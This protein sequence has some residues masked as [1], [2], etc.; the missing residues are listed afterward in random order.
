MLAGKTVPAVLFALGLLTSYLLSSFLTFYP[1]STAYHGAVFLKTLLDCI[2][3][4]LEGMRSPYFI[5]IVGL[6]KLSLWRSDIILEL[7]FWRCPSGQSPL[8]H[9]RAPDDR[10]GALP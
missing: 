10:G 3:V 8:A 5:G 4:T 6:L 2:Q 1:D 7:V 9:W